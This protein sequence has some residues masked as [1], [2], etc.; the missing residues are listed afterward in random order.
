M[1]KIELQKYNKFRTLLVIIPHMYHNLQQ[2][3]PHAIPFAYSLI[4]YPSF[5]IVTFGKL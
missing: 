4:S 1:F 5:G 3:K 2:L